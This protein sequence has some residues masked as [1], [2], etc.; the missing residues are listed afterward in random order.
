MGG[1]FQ[2]KCKPQ[3][4]MSSFVKKMCGRERKR[5]RKRK[6]AICMGREEGRRE[7]GLIGKVPHSLP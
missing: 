5:K 4:K 7:E 1:C 6:T 2:R 3:Y